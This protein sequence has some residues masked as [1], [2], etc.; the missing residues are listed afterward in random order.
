[1]H[2]TGAT[3]RP[4]YEAESLILQVTA[5]CSHNA[6]TFCSMYRDIPFEES[7]LDEIEHDVRESA[8]F[9]PHVQRVF[10]ANG[11]AFCLPANRLAAIAQIIHQYLPNVRSIGSYASIRNIQDK[12]DSELAMLAQMGFSDL[13]IGL[14]SGLDD[15]LLYMNKGYD[16][17]EAR[18]QM[19]RLH[20]AGLPFNVN[21]INAAAGPNRILEAAQ[22]N[23]AIVN[24][25]QPSLIFV[26]PLHVDPGSK[27]EFDVASG[28]FEECTLGQY[29]TEEIEFLRGLEM[30]NCIFFGLHVSNPVPVAGFLPQDKDKLVAKLEEG[31]AAI[32]QATLD[33]H[34]PKGTEGRLFF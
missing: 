33:S 10:L 9:R 13:N 2:Y 30:D 16:S 12:T 22:A 23:A 17:A 15:V 26:S 1:M 25:A 3:Y 11:D 28:V 6:C 29:I 34:P 19:K 20:D 32:P 5:G 21:I 24:D 27:L 4:P 14:E 31:M 8:I 18:F 7:P